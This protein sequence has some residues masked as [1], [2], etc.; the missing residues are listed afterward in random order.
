MRRVITAWAEEKKC[1]IGRPA[2]GRTK[3]MGRPQS[4]K[5]AHGLLQTGK[6]GVRDRNAPPKP[7]CRVLATGNNRLLNRVR[8]ERNLLSRDAG[9]LADHVLCIAGS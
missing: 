8:F 3:V 4:G 7:E 5:N 1:Q 2:I 6:D 9:R